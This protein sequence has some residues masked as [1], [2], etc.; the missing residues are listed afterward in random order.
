MASLDRTPVFHQRWRD[1]LFLHWPLSAGG[2]RPRIPAGLELDL[3]EGQAWLTLIPFLI[4]ESRPAGF[5][6]ALASRL[7]EVNL[8]TYVRGPDG[9]PGIYFWSLDASSVAAVVAARLLYGLPY[10]PAAMS[11]Q[12]NGDRVDYASRRRLGGRGQ[13]SASWTV[14]ESIGVAVP[15]TRDHFLVERYS[16]YVKRWHRVYRARVRHRSYPLHRV[17]VHTL[18][19]SLRS[20][21]RLPV[22]GDLPVIHYSPGVDVDIFWPAHVAPRPL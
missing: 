12:K 13:F 21:G 1:L 4:A 18:A 16:L 22:S 5:P 8:R 14:G 19:E 9:E 20:A 2:L 3:F 17:R 6:S 11:M 15:G 7:L 10:F